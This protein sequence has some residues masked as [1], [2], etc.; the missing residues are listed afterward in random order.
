MARQNY[1][2]TKGLGERVN[3]ASPNS[4]SPARRSQNNNFMGEGL[5]PLATASNPSGTEIDSRI[6]DDPVAPRT[7]QEQNSPFHKANLSSNLGENDT[8][9]INRDTSPRVD[10]NQL[11][12]A[13][14]Q[15]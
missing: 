10:L 15:R 14:R 9:D 5:N 3:S 6:L 7:F 11:A 1:V 12:H 2:T 13:N 4:R 8:E